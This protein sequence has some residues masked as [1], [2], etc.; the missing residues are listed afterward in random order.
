L[1]KKEEELAHFKFV[2]GSNIVKRKKLNKFGD[3]FGKIFKKKN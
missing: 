1:G 3:I 2:E